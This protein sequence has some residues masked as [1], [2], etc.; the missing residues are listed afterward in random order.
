MLSDPSTVLEADRG[1]GRLDGG[2]FRERTHF[3]QASAAS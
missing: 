2:A 1:E 3:I